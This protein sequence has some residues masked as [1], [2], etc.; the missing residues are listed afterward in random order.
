MTVFVAG[1]HGV[2]KSYLCQQ[3]ALKYGVVHES[4]SGLIRRERSL[5]EWSADKRV[6]SIDDNQVALRSAVKRINASGDRLLLDGH[7]VL[8]NP[9]SEFV[10][11]NSSVFDDLDLKGVILIEAAPDVISSRLSLRDS[12]QSSVDINSFLEE[13]QAHAQRICNI[14]NVPLQIMFSPGFQEFSGA[15]SS[16]IKK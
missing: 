7:F 3:Y 5:A 13:E 2:G 6:Q 1:V 4:A 8:I 14:I 9:A 11:L 12:L 15:V 16:F 10:L